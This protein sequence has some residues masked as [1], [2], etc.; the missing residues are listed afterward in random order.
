MLAAVL[1]LAASASWGIGDFLGGVKSRTLHPLAVMSVSQP[2]GLALLGGTAEA[3]CLYHANQLDAV[4]AT[5]PVETQS[6]R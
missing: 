2:V 5:R 6:D 3:S 1:A 4:A